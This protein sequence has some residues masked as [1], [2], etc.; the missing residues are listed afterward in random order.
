[1]I[2]D[3]NGRNKIMTEQCAIK[4]FKNVAKTGNVNKKTQ[5]SKSDD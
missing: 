1:M 5:T 2:I 4:F 3:L